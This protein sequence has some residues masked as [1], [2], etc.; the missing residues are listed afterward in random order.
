MLKVILAIL[1]L[2]LFFGYIHIPG[3]TFPNITFFVIN[4]HPITLWNL[5]VSLAMG[6]LIGLL[7]YPFK[8]I[9]GIA[10]L[11][12]TLSILGLISI[13]GLSTYITI[14]VILSLVLFVIFGV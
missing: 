8:G 11:L 4:G 12:H 3:L 9:V 2:A 5:I 13:A 14:A 7:P 10:L 6:V 1:V